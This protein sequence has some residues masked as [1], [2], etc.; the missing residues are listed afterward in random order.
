MSVAARPAKHMSMMR[1]GVWN[2]WH[3][4]IK[5]S[6]GCANCYVYR[7]DALYGKD[8]TQVARTGEFDLPLRKK[9][10]GSF[11]IPSGSGIFACM[12]SDFFIET[13]DEWRGE[14]WEM[15]RLRSDVDFTIITKRVPWIYKCLPDNWGSG[16][17]NVSIGATVENQCRADERLDEFIDLPIKHKFLVCEP[18]LGSLNVERWLKTGKIERL[19]VGGESGSGARPLD[20][21][22]VLALREECLRTG[23]GFHFKQTG[24]RFV[25][26]GKLYNIER[27]LQIPQARRAG[28]DIPPR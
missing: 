16:W 7:R 27:M 24:A 23:T 12:T 15:M 28:I 20:Y 17:E 10:D 6:E 4:C 26:D 9:R 21:A 13:A 1:E 3:G 5:Y 11:K 14:A 18:L 25:K 19:I 8:S 22:W 2:P